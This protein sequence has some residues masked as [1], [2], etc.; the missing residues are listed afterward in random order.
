MTRC[1]KLFFIY[2][3]WFRFGGVEKYLKISMKKNSRR[4]IKF[5]D[6]HLSRVIDLFA[7]EQILTAFFALLN[8]RF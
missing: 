3:M 8:V 5:P 6:W 4:V 1:N 2:I 7:Q